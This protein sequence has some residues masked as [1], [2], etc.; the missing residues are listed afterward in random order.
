MDG[1]AVTTTRASS[2]TMKYATDVN[3]TVSTWLEGPDTAPAARGTAR[4]F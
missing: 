2:V 1:R 4:P 3:N